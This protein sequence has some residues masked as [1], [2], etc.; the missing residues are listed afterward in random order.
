MWRTVPAGSRTQAG[1][2]TGPVGGDR[3]AP[4]KM[5]AIDEARRTAGQNE[6]ARIAEI[7]RRARMIRT[8]A[9][10]VTARAMGRRVRAAEDAR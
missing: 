1:G 10:A 9:G 7:A 3:A 5:A 4:V 8:V 6:I 2:A